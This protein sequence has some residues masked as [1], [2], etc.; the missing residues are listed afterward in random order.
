MNT[1]CLVFVFIAFA[2]PAIVFLGLADCRIRA[3]L[4]IVRQTPKIVN[5]QGKYWRYTCKLQ[6]YSFKPAMKTCV[7]GQLFV[8]ATW[9]FCRSLG[10]QNLFM[11]SFRSNVFLYIILLLSHPALNSQGNKCPTGVASGCKTFVVLP[12]SRRESCSQLIC[13]PI[14]GLHVNGSFSELELAK[15]IL[16]TWQRDPV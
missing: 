2:F 10:R 3:D 1:D 9:Q 11:D 4:A 7:Y 12:Q 16:R 14:Y 8:L 13:E 15:V 6:P 5:G